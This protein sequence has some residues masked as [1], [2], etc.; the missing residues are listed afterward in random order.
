MQQQLG[1]DLRRVHVHAARDQHV[2]LPPGDVVEALLV[3]AGEIARVEPAVGI[4]RRRGRLRVVPVALADVRPAQP[5]LA[6]LVGR[7]LGAVRQR[8]AGLGE[9]HR[10]ADRALLPHRLLDGHREAVHADLGQAVALLEDHAALLVRLDDVER[11]RGAAADQPAHVRQVDRLEL[12]RLHQELVDRGH[13][14][15]DRAPLAFQR[16]PDLRR[17]RTPRGARSCRRCRRSAAGTRRGR[18]RGRAA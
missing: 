3:A 8:R 18:R 12:R 2:L 11:Q 14:E 13:A 17:D 9:H 6:H 15:H 1:F 5:Q 7:R 16:P 10:L 4:Q